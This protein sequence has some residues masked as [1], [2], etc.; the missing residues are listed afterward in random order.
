[1][2]RQNPHSVYAAVIPQFIEALLHGQSPGVFGDGEQSR[3]FV[4]IDDVIQANLLALSREHLHGDVINVASGRN[5][6]LNQLLNTLRNIMNSKIMSVC[7]KARPGD[8]RHSLG[9]IQ[10]ARRML[11]FAPNV[12]IKAGLEKTIAYFMRKR[13]ETVKK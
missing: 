8:I 10:K 11:R 13:R 12:E 2:P 9:D 4:F 7:R 6:S 1:V 3:D 5:L